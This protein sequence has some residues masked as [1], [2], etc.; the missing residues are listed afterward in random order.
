[1]G[2]DASFF[3]QGPQTTPFDWIIGKLRNMYWGNNMKLYEKTYQSTKL[4]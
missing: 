3:K 2:K 1:M 4:T